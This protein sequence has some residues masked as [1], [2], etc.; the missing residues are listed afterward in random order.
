MKGGKVVDRIV[1][2]VDILPTVADIVDA[3]TPANPYDGISVRPLLCGRKQGRDR[4]LYLGLGAAVSR[5]HKLIKA[6]KD[7]GLRLKEDY[8][9]N[10]RKN[11]CEKSDGVLK[12][13]R[14]Q[15]K[16]LGSVIEQYDSIKPAMPE[17]PYGKGKKG[18]K[19]P[20]EWNI[21]EPRYE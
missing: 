12:G 4:I 2:F 10:I 6:N 1:S 19:A 17:Q 13:N 8:F 20:K 16:R 11:P 9:T 5:K 7:K 14:K 18:F 3:R 21:A 15:K